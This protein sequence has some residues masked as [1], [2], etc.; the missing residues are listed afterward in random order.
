MG[1]RAD[2]GGEL[3]RY[4]VGA[5]GDWVQGDVLLEK[6]LIQT[7][8]KGLRRV[9]YHEVQSYATPS[10]IYSKPVS[11]VYIPTWAPIPFRLFGTGDGARVLPVSRLERVCLF[12]GHIDV[13]SW[14]AS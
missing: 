1:W 14:A 6:H 2:Q 12:G 7:V 11:S 5:A 8:E 9:T 4:A 10:G 3:G 13:L